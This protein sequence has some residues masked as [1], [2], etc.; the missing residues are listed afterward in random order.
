[1]KWLKTLTYCRLTL[2]KGN[3]QHENCPFFNEIKKDSIFFQK[4]QG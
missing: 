4:K 1:M 3:F 2:K